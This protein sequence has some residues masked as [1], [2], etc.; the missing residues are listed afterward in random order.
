MLEIDLKGAAYFKPDTNEISNVPTDGPIAIYFDGNAHSKEA[1]INQNCDKTTV[2][3]TEYTLLAIRRNTVELSLDGTLSGTIIYQATPT[4]ESEQTTIELANVKPINPTLKKI[5]FKFSNGEPETISGGNWSKNIMLN[6]VFTWTDEKPFF[7]RNEGDCIKSETKEVYDENGTPSGMYVKMTIPGIRKFVAAGYHAEFTDPE[8]VTIETQEQ[9]DNYKAIGTAIDNS[10][11]DIEGYDKDAIIGSTVISGQVSVGYASCISENFSSLLENAGNVWYKY[12][13]PASDTFQIE[14][15]RRNSLYDNNKITRAL[16]YVNM[17]TDHWYNL[18]I[19]RTILSGN[20]SMEFTLT[21]ID[22]DGT[23]A[24]VPTKSTW[25]FPVYVTDNRVLDGL[26]TSCDMPE[27]KFTDEITTGLENY[28]ERYQI[29]FDAC[30]RSLY[31]QVYYD[32]GTENYAIWSNAYDFTEDEYEDQNLEGKGVTK[33]SRILDGITDPMTTIG[34]YG[35]KTNLEVGI[36]ANEKFKEFAKNYLSDNEESNSLN[37]VGTNGEKLCKYY[38]PRRIMYN[39][40]SDRYWT[41]VRRDSEMHIES[42]PGMEVGGIM[43][44]STPNLHTTGNYYEMANNSHNRVKEYAEFFG[45]PQNRLPIVHY[46]Q[47]ILDSDYAT[48]V[49][50]SCESKTG[51]RNLSEISNDI[52]YDYKNNPR[53][54]AFV[55]DNAKVT[56]TE[57]YGKSNSLVW[58]RNSCSEYVSE[59]GSIYN[60]TDL[61]GETT[62]TVNISADSML[63]RQAVVYPVLGNPFT[64]E[65]KTNGNIAVKSDEKIIVTAAFGSNTN[66]YPVNSVMVYSGDEITSFDK[67]RKTYIYLKQ[68]EDG[69]SCNLGSTQ[70]KP[71]FVDSVQ[72]NNASCAEK[73][74]FLPNPSITVTLTNEQKDSVL[75]SESMGNSDSLSITSDEASFFKNGNASGEFEESSKIFG[76]TDEFKS[77]SLFNNDTQLIDMISSGTGNSGKKVKFQ[78]NRLAIQCKNTINTLES[79][80]FNVFYDAD[81]FAT[82]DNMDPVEDKKWTTTKCFYFDGGLVPDSIG[83]NRSGYETI[84]GVSET[85]ENQLAS[86]MNAVYLEKSNGV[87]VEPSIASIW[88]DTSTSPTKGDYTKFIKNSEIPEGTTGHALFDKFMSVNVTGARVTIRKEHLS[89]APIWI[90]IYLLKFVEDIGDGTDGYMWINDESLDIDFRDDYSDEYANAFADKTVDKQF[91]QIPGH[92]DLTKNVFGIKFVIKQIVPQNNKF[93]SCTIDDIRVFASN[94]LNKYGQALSVDDKFIRKADACLGD[95]YGIDVKEYVWR[96]PSTKSEWQTLRNILT[97]DSTTNNEFITASQ[98]A[99]INNNINLLSDGGTGTIEEQLSQDGDKF[100]FLNTYY[101]TDG[102]GEYDANDM[103]DIV[104]DGRIGSASEISIEWKYIDYVYVCYSSETD[105]AEQLLDKYFGNSIFNSLKSKLISNIASLNSNSAFKNRFTFSGGIAVQDSGTRIEQE[106]NLS[107]D[108]KTS[109]TVTKDW[110]EVFTVTTYDTEQVKM[111]QRRDLVHVE[112]WRTRHNKKSKHCHHTPY[113]HPGH[114]T[115]TSSYSYTVDSWTSE[116][117]RG[118]EDVISSDVEQYDETHSYNSII[119]N[120]KYSSVE[121]WFSYFTPEQ[122]KFRID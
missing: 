51:Y 64:I 105:N 108:W 7:C 22:N 81:K 53:S 71:V 20:S 12:T 90:K 16:Y 27:D 41:F 74:E 49:W 82:V 102:P 30:N 44:V 2:D 55:W 66:G 29:K 54:V 98:M 1:Y 116:T 11:V 97:E 14:V 62:G 65:K 35:S 63:Q 107:F 60:H 89:T 61:A 26:K 68:S 36:F 83:N 19:N 13:P 9:L 23:L 117:I 46:S 58:T 121:N 52:I 100:S 87:E 113:E 39:G 34:Q 94:K 28:N 115:C 112:N 67:S 21:D 3:E 104:S 25:L 4:E 110:Q 93:S 96:L 45:N 42:I 111:T 50:N 77:I 86:E 75:V 31:D 88:M 70:E 6:K 73:F 101:I 37:S 119:A 5:G 8:S 103:S 76:Y 43:Y 114:W 40:S 109:E 10:G 78:C 95:F 80:V 118:T 122:I 92:E 18:A 24:N 79:K 38:V 15:I 17:E 106:N 47:R 69:G 91:I 59:T 48:F 33:I 32:N 57:S 99:A 56:R 120:P 72:G 84:I 85:N